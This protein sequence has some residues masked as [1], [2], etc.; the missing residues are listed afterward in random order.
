MRPLPAVLLDLYEDLVTGKLVLRRGRVTK[1]VDLVNGNPVSTASTQRDETLGHFLVG[2]GVISE[3]HHRL[4]VERAAAGSSKLGEALVSMQIL[5]FE[6]LIMQLGKQA[7]HKIVQA[8]RWPQGAWRFDE[9]PPVEGMQLRMV[10]VVLGGLRES[11]VED[12]SRL[13]RL[14]GMTFELTERGQRLRGELKRLYGDKPVGMLGDGAP[15]AFLEKAFGDRAAA[16]VAVDAMLLCD[17][18]TARG[19]DVGLGAGGGGSAARTRAGTG[20]LQLPAMPNVSRTRT[21]RPEDGGDG[22]Y[23]ML[24]GDEAESFEHVAPTK[25]GS[26]P[27]DYTEMTIEHE[28]SGVVSTAELERANKLREHAIALRTA[29]M[30]EYQRI[31]GADL[32]AV[33]LVDR[34]AEAAD[35]TASHDIKISLLERNTASV[36]DENDRA[37]L[38]E[39]RASYDNAHAILIDPRKRTAYDRELAG[40]ELVQVPPALDT[41]LDYRRAEE[42][43][44]RQ[45]WPTA[46]GLL[47]RVVSRSPGEADYHA[48]LG[49]AEWHAGGHTVAA[50]DVAHGHINAALAINPD[51]A[52]SHDYK[53]RIDAAIGVDDT[54]A[55]FNLER[56]IDLDP[57]RDDAIQ[58]VHALL[59][60]RGEL[61]RLERVLKKVVF[62]L[63]AK[64]GA[65]EAVAW[66]RLARLYIEQLGDPDAAASAIDNARKLA[67]TAKEV[68]AFDQHKLD[69]FLTTNQ[70]R[71]GW[72][73]A[74]GDT[75]EGSQLVASTAAAGHV[76]AAFLAAATMVALGTADA[77]MT[78]LYDK[79]RVRGMVEIATP[80]GREQWALLR[81]RDDTLEL[82]A[83]LELVAPAIHALAPMTL[84]DGELDDSQR[85]APK[86][87]PPAFA[88]ARARLASLIGVSDAPIYARP[89]LGAQIHVIASDPPVLVAGDEALTSPERPEL[90]FRLG[91]ALTFLW[92]GRAVGASR[93]GRVLRAVVLAVVREAAGTELGAGEPLSAPAEAAIGKLEPEVRAQA[94]AAALRLLSRSSTGLNLSAWA[95][96]LARTAD[97]AGMLLCGD[98]PAAFAGAKDMGELDRDLVE[99]AYSAAHVAL[100]S[101]LGLS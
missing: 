69:H 58:A 99:F 94:R 57:T 91:R 55:A 46:V 50:A 23:G 33:L 18:I 37:K 86:D 5:T 26:S 9:A 16:R 74:L 71:A 29:I 100:R 64:G 35:V 88:R 32:Y 92:P 7:R 17:A 63:R 30:A 13:T 44:A 6:Q 12:L 56:A 68:I 14:D 73:E 41:E 60:A 52:A 2:S 28:T 101:Q 22:L 34:D 66:V 72:R 10:E 84:A 27:L 3:E 24:F 96:A 67:P 38:A 83:L 31:Q 40:G 21:A 93:P 82:G 76:D 42:A 77:A 89:E 48:A 1:T 51:H 85:V 25:S 43:I 78:A 81:H 45:L 53:G 97:R 62:R 65:A 4:A 87:L 90:A 8:L 15:I 36:T 80:L 19:A 11:A 59:V 49:W 95:K 75:R 70:Q 54:G 47:K 20:G 39:I 79:G 98:V 61:R